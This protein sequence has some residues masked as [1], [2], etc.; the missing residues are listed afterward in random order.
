MQLNLLEIGKMSGGV[1]LEQLVQSGTEKG[2]LIADD[3]PEAELRNV[4]QTIDILQQECL[5]RLSW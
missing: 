4:Q 5:K 3:A 2:L 1:L